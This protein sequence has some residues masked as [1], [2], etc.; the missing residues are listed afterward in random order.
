MKGLDIPAHIYLIVGLLTLIAIAPLPYGYYT[1]MR[2]IVCGCSGYIAYNLYLN[3]DRNAWLWIFGIIAILFNPFA[4]I[5]MIKEIWMI[6]DALVGGLFLLL[7]YRSY[8]TDK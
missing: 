4:P 5:H 6:V 2:F 8:K 7:S 1:F 3:N